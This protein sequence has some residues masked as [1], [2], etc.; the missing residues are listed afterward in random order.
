MKEARPEA[1]RLD[2]FGED[3]GT[4]AG[5]APAAPGGDAQAGSAPTRRS[6]SGEGAAPRP[7][8]GAPAAGERTEDGSGA[9]ADQEAR[10][11]AWR[12]LVGGEYKDLYTE[13]TQRIIDRRFREAKLAEGELDRLRPVVE[14]LEQRYQ[15]TGGDTEGLL[16]AMEQEDRARESQRERDAVRAAQL[17]TQAA[18]QQ[19]RSWDGEF[20][21]LRERFPQADLAEEAKDPRFLALLGARVPLAQAYGA[22]HLDELLRQE[23]QTAEKQVVDHIR[24]KGVRP[25]ENG[26]SGQGAFTVKDDVSRLSR[27]QRAELA[28]RAAKGET[29]TF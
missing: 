18:R 19:L 12:A 3:G 5:A 10:R 25:A 21:A 2:L 11:R 23:R 14:R 4:Q 16:R 9:G 24:A 6:T 28:R 1:A 7:R 20:R 26:A 15:L 29:I 27:R 8:E 22:I 17:R 13:D